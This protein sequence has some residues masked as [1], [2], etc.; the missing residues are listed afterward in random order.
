MGLAVTGAQWVCLRE[1]SGIAGDP[2]SI[3]KTS[4]LYRTTRRGKADYCSILGL[5]QVSRKDIVSC[6]ADREMEERTTLLE[7]TLLGCSLK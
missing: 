3:R 4:E 2:W 7:D 5:F 6:M 1:G